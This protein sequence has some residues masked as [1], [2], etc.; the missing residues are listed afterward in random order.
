MKNDRKH[1]PPIIAALIG[2]LMIFAGPCQAQ[3]QDANSAISSQPELV[4]G[5]KEAPPFAMKAAD[6]NWQGISIDLWRRIADELHLR[7]RFAEEAGVQGL[8]DGVATGKFDIAAAAITVTAERARI[9]DFTQPFYATGLGIAV[10]VGGEPS[11]E[12]IIRTVTSFGFAQAI[13]ALVGLALV[14]GFLVWLFERRHNEDF[15]GSAIKGLSAGVW[16]SAVAMTQ[17]HTGDLS[18]RTLSGRIV[19]IVWMIASIVTI[20]VFTASITSVLTI[21]HLQGEVHGVSDLSAARVGAVTGTS[22]EDALS[23]LRIPYRKFSTPQDGLK[24]LRTHSLDAFVY[25]RPLL[26]WII[27]QGF[28][29]SIELIDPTFGSEEYA[30]VLPS[31]SPLRKAL[32]VA[33]LDAIHSDWWGQTTFRYLGSR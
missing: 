13:M 7:Y 19:A 31:N 23:R 29:S 14:V 9:L 26:A 16:W 6:G 18:P 25:D 1:G 22:T 12:P 21:K 30:F 15:G 2:A 3:T 24:A 4:I 17:R 32:D 8:I 10:P 11:W 5:T 20:A 33:I 28:S 27:Q